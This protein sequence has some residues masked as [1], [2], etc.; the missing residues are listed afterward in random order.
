[1]LVECV[2]ELSCGEMRR[3]AEASERNQKYPALRRGTQGQYKL[4]ACSRCVATAQNIAE[5]EAVTRAARP[6]KGAGSI[7][8]AAKR[9]A[10]F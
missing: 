2:D 8:H 6:N 9:V 5:H 4:Y 3:C 1:M 10:K 7:D